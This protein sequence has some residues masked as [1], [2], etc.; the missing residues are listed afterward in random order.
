M[1][2]QILLALLGTA[3]AGLLLS[4]ERGHGQPIDSARSIGGDPVDRARPNV[5][6]L[7]HSAG[8]KH[9]V[10]P[11]SQ[12]IFKEIAERTRAF[13]LTATD[14]C[15]LLSREALKKYDAVVFYTT[16]EL[17]ISA[18]QKAAFL[19]FIKSGKGFVGIH[20]ATDTFYKWPEYGELIGGYFDQHPWHQEV[21]IAVEDQRHPA[22]RHLGKQFKMTDEIY[23]F[24]DF[25]RNSVNVLLRLDVTSVD[26][27]KPAVHR[28]DK[29]FALAWWRK[30]GNGR[31]FYT[32]LGHR[33]EVWRD[34]RFQQAPPGRG[35]LGNGFVKPLGAQASCL[36]RRKSTGATKAGKMPALPGRGGEWPNKN[37]MT[38]SL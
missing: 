15:S 31:V 22:T 4:S 24:K 37:S 8:F 19:D 20:S 21:T 9:D 25:S 38:P 18:E 27:N 5:L 1:S 30:Y 36:L 13:E 7:T 29:D 33:P 32:A 26:L 35:A 10:L 16:G 23:Q 17:P 34:D 14:D 2:K 6:Y 3:L 28:T 11:L 12:Q